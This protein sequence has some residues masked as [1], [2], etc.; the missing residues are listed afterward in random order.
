MKITGAELFVKALKEENVDTLFAYPGG[1]AIDLFHALYGEKEI[2]VILPRHEQGL[3]HAADGYARSTG[4]TG[5]CLVTSGPGAT[6]LVTGIATANYDSVPLV[7]FTGQVPTRLIGN[8]AF[9]EVDIVGITRSVCK[10]AVTVRRRED[11]AETIKKAFAIAKSGKP[12]PVVIDLP[13]DIQRA[14]GSDVYPK[15]ITVR[16]YKPN[17]SVHTGQLQKAL[18]ALKHSKKPLFLIGGGVNIARANAEMTRLVEITGVPAVTTIMGKGGIPTASS[19]YAGNIGIHGS[20]AANTAVSSC[21]VLFSI[22]TRFNDRI[23]G[24]IE[25]FAPNASIIHIDID[26]SAIS[27][28]IV[29]DIPIVAD[30]KKAILSLLDKAKPLQISEWASQI[31]NWKKKHPIDMGIG[32]TPQK[33]IEAINECFSNAVI[34]ADVGQNQ[35][36]TTQFLELDENKKML[37]SGGLG[38][39]GYGLPAAIGA[40]LGNPEKDVI[41]V[42]GDGGMQMNIQ[43]LATAVVYELPVIICVLNNGYLGNVRQWQE[44]FYDRHY[45]STCMRY[46]RSCETGCNA[47]NPCCPEYTPDFIKLAESYGAKGI[48]VTKT[49]EVKPALLLAKQSRKTPTV[50]EFIID[51]ESNVLPIVPPGNAL[52]D[53]VFHNP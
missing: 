24:K 7:C 15:E 9:Q 39:M 23:T 31:R 8:D 34:A 50:I 14:Y 11:L 27:R 40:K 21:D 44:M 28:N 1:Q 38:T 35:M 2:D 43:E 4:K 51:R 53:M 49:E 16:G 22:G 45:S 33:I 3:I 30:A 46:R 25:E 36:W 42:C 19:L 12:G 48:R 41:A 52:K 32:M 5:V 17:S 6:N 10:Y 47:P 37:T 26:A 29:V 20:Y 18:D 13:K